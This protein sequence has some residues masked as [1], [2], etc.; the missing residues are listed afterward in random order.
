MALFL[1]RSEYQIISI[2]G[3]WKSGAAYVPIDTNNPDNRIE[4]IF[5]DINAK[6]VITNECYVERIRRIMLLRGIPL[7]VI[8]IESL[9]ISEMPKGNL[10]NI[11]T[12][13]NLAYVIYT[14][15]S[16]GVPKGVLGKLEVRIPHV[17]LSKSAFPGGF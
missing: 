9:S 1:D 2:L 8:A 4:F 10:K 3:V 7:S 15:G 12:P 16:T 17:S 6:I 13:N 5:D 11:C 14:S